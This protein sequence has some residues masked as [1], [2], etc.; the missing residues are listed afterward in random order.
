[1]FAAMTGLDRALF[2]AVADTSGTDAERAAR[3]RALVAEGANPAARDKYGAA[4]LHRAV[5][6]WY[7][8]HDPLPSLDVV[9]ALA[10]VSENGRLR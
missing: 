6:P 7:Q 9:R 5:T 1:M 4:L 2:D 3:V 10:G 8:R